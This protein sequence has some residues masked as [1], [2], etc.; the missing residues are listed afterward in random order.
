[1]IGPACW[2][3]ASSTPVSCENPQSALPRQR[4]PAFGLS[5]K[6]FSHS[7]AP[8][9]I[10]V[11]RPWQAGFQPGRFAARAHLRKI[12]PI[13]QG[14]SPQEPQK[15]SIPPN[16]SSRFRARSS[17]AARFSAPRTTAGATARP[18]ATA[19]T[20]EKSIMRGLFLARIAQHQSRSPP[21]QGYLT[22]RHH[23]GCAIP[24][25]RGIP[26]HVR[27]SRSQGGTNSSLQRQ[28][29]RLEAKI[30]LSGQTRRRLASA[31]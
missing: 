5:P 2:R 21:G 6:S 19:L 12:C 8:P 11:F 4:G 29:S 26:R 23:N 17:R 9:R 31:C 16:R 1:M 28:V 3:T 25:A 30:R 7:P 24:L 14:Q 15:P 20:A 22:S 18:R 10:A 13:P 27:R